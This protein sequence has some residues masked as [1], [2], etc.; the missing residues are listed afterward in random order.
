RAAPTRSRSA[1]RAAAVPFL[2]TARS[3]TRRG[4]LRGPAHGGHPPQRRG[5]P[6]AALDLAPPGRLGARALRA[7]V[8]PRDD[9]GCSAPPHAVVEES[10][11][12]SG[13][14]RSGAAAGLCRAA[15]GRVGGRPTRS[16]S[17]CLSRRSTHP[18]GCRP[19]LRLGHTRRAL[20]D[21]LTLAGPVGARLVLRAVSLQRGPGAALA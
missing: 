8:L 5:R 14:G 4:G 15:P 1:A 3:R 18:P 6:R 20:L 7:E 19:R 16:A 11:E 9:P 10:Q 21:R 13:P 12:A 2:P 17:R